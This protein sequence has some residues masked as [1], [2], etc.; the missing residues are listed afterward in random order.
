MPDG[1]S[2][3]GV[4]RL[5]VGRPAFAASAKRLVR[6][7]GGTKPA[8]FAEFP[9]DRLAVVPE[10]LQRGGIVQHLAAVEVDE[11]TA[12][13]AGRCLG[14]VDRAGAGESVAGHGFS[15][16]DFRLL[17]A[18]LD[19][20]L[21]GDGFALGHLGLRLPVLLSADGLLGLQL[22]GVVEQRLRVPCVGIGATLVGC[23]AGTL[24]GFTGCNVGAGGGADFAQHVVVTVVDGLRSQIIG[25]RDVHH[26]TAPKEM[27]GQGALRARSRVP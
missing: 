5:A 3:A 9:R 27:E 22:V 25:G 18:G 11:V 13:A 20:V 24:R 19:L 16:V 7:A 4:H 10:T 8:T 12:L 14:G 6:Y 26:W 2:G 21:N 17:C 15:K 23:E 1:G